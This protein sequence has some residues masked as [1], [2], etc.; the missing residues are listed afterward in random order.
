[1]GGKKPIHVSG[2]QQRFMLVVKIHLLLFA[3]K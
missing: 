3:L 1:V 2:E